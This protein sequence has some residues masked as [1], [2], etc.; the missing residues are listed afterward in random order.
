MEATFG[1]GMQ[2]SRCGG[3]TCCGAGMLGVQAL[4]H[5]GSGVVTPR[6]LHMGSVVVVNGLSS[7]GSK[8]DPPG[9]GIEPVSAAQ[10]AL[11]H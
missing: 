7:I 3:F 8:W 9:P 10:L 1:C 2:A 6:P 5:I 4:Q 11:Y